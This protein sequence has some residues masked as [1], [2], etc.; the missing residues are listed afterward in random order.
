MT[1]P[2]PI[3]SDRVLLRRLKISDL[4]AFQ[5]Y[6]YDAEV[7]RY[8]GWSPQSDDQSRAFISKM[9]SAEFPTP[10]EWFQLGIVLAQEDAL[11]GDIGIYLSKDLGEA[12]IGF[13]LR[14]ESQGFGLGAEA[15]KLVIDM[16]FVSVGVHKIVAITDSRNTAS[17]RL[18]ENVGMS[19][20][21]TV[22]AVFR[23][24]PCMEHIYELTSL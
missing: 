22:E 5:A 7:G 24:M 20:S 16:L 21:R 3:Q 11:I 1:E 10:G 23:D 8:Q 9:N 2:I 19:L 12:E 15:V 6:R 18:L 13:T 14:A 4:P 17:I